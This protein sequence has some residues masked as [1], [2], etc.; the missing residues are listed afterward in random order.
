MVVGA[1]YLHLGKKYYR[2][3]TLKRREPFEESEH[4][5]LQYLPICWQLREGREW[6]HS[7]G[8]K[9][10]QMRV[11]LLSVSLAC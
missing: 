11:G 9:N 7:G 2:P 5:Q 1:F 10:Y 8:K 4:F 6:D 3:Q